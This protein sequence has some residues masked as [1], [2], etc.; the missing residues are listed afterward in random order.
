VLLNLEM[1]GGVLGQDKNI[2]KIKTHSW[3]TDYLISIIKSWKYE[4][5]SCPKVVKTKLLHSCL[6]KENK[7]VNDETK[8][9]EHFNF[10]KTELLM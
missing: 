10:E 8:S 7:M 6:C 2:L 1:I 9:K 4:N 5:V 3:N